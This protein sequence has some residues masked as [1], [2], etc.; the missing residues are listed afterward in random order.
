MFV[1]I[2][3]LFMGL[4]GVVAHPEE[5]PSNKVEAKTAYTSLS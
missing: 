5:I 2:Y 3:V 1:S 4:G